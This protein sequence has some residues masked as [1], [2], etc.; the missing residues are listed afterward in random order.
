MSFDFTLKDSDSKDLFYIEEQDDNLLIASSIY[1]MMQQ[2]NAKH[3]MFLLTYLRAT[4]GYFYSEL[5][6]TKKDL[7]AYTCKLLLIMKKRINKVYLVKH[8]P[9]QYGMGLNIEL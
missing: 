8:R 2:C 1:F 7:R 4:P 5:N 9:I 3:S 6:W